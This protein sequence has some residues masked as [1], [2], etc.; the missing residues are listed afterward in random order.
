M[1]NTLEDLRRNRVTQAE[2]IQGLK[3]GIAELES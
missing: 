2:E 1:E 3:D